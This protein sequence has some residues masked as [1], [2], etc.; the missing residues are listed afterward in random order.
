[1]GKRGHQFGTTTG[2]P[3]RCG[4]LDLNLIRYTHM[5]NGYTSLNITKLDILDTFSTIKVCVGYKLNGK[6]IRIIPST[7]QD[8]QK[9]EPIYETVKGWNKDTTKV[10]KAQELPKEAV[11]YIRLIERHTGIKVS[12]VGTGPGNDA[13]V[14]M[15]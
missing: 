10:R 14:K 11:E 8:L 9:V 4:W 1:M 15:I 7:L 13:M 2:R 5:I 12:W 6:Q 3:R